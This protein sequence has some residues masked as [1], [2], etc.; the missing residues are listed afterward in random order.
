M[1]IEAEGRHEALIDRKTWLELQ[2][3]LKQR[4]ENRRP[5]AAWLWSGLLVCDH[6][7]GNMYANKSLGGWGK[8]QEWRYYICGTWKRTRQCQ[9]NAIQERHVTAETVAHLRHLYESSL[10]AGDIDNALAGDEIAWRDPRPGLIE[11]RSAIENRR[12]RLL[13][14]YESGGLDVN[15]FLGRDNGLL[16]QLETINIEITEADARAT[17]LNNR[18]TSIALISDLLPTLETRLDSAD[19]IQANRWLRQIFRRIIIRDR[20]VVRVEI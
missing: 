13:D 10:D 5:P 18:Q 2:D 6:C 16:S 11:Q 7:A 19:P 20:H 8:Q 17:E 15:R 9:R 12:N 1:T 14:L 3:W 4:A